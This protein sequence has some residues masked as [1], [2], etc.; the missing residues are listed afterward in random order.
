MGKQQHT[1]H[2]HEGRGEKEKETFLPP[3]KVAKIKIKA[4]KIW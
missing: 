2:R 1:T 4:P 3:T